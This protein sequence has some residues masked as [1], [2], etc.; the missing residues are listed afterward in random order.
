[1]P[2][3]GQDLIS[4]L[5]VVDSVKPAR[6]PGRVNGWPSCL[7]AVAEKRREPLLGKRRSYGEFKYKTSA[8]ERLCREVQDTRIGDTGLGAGGCDDEVDPAKEALIVRLFSSPVRLVPGF[9]RT[10]NK[11]EARIGPVLS[12]L[13]RDYHV[14]VQVP[15]LRTA[16]CVSPDLALMVNNRL[17]TKLQHLDVLLAQ[18]RARREKV[19]VLVEME[20]MLAL[21]RQYLQSRQFPFVYLDPSANK[22][23][24]QRQ[25]ARFAKRAEN[26]CLLASSTASCRGVAELLTSDVSNVV[27]Y[28]SSPCLAPKE[29]SRWVRILKRS[30]RSTLTLYRLV[31][32]GSVESN[33]SRKALQEKLL[34]DLRRSPEN[35]FMWK[36][37]KDTLDDLLKITDNPGDSVTE[38]VYIAGACAEVSIRY[39]FRV[40]MFP[41]NRCWYVAGTTTT[42][43]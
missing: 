36:I 25:M 17:S 7:N 40:R 8:L 23:S 15:D 34:I 5:T 12:Q 10:I 1:M 24:R 11:L 20:D 28:D 42:E 21:L 41:K 30:S 43:P 4:S 6:T 39:G 18:I 27:F 33:L 19:L 22:S 38:S 14:P 2:L 26:V 37:K 31:C 35:G 29:A 13:S 16:H 9:S 3:Y 32:E